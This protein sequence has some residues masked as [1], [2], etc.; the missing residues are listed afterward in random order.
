MAWKRE[1]SGWGRQALS[2]GYGRLPERERRCHK[3]HL[4]LLSLGQ[5]SAIFLPASG[6]KERKTP[7]CG[8]PHFRFSALGP[9]KSRQIS[10]RERRSRSPAA[11]DSPSV[12][13]PIQPAGRVCVRAPSGL[14][15]TFHSPIPHSCGLVHGWPNPD[16]QARSEA[17]KQKPSR[18]LPKSP[19]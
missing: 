16:L 14:Q 12:S 18:F 5:N 6:I 1:R 17:A 11:S 2:R 8:K 3:Q 13:Y 7:M 4:P 19:L 10:R 15:D 9:E